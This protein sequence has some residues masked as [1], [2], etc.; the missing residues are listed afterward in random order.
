MHKKKILYYMAE[1]PFSSEAGNLTRCRQLLQYFEARR[2][3]MDVDFISSINWDEDGKT[4][5]ELHY[6]SLGLMIVPFKMEK[7]NII[8]YFLTDKLP[9]EINKILNTSDID[10]VSPYFKKTLKR[11]ISE[12]RYDIVIISYAE[13]GNVIDSDIDAYKILDTHDFTTL[14]L[15][16]KEQGDE[17]IKMGDRFES[18]MNILKKFDEIW[19]YSIEEQFIFEQFAKKKVSLLPISFNTNTTDIAKKDRAYDILYVASANFHNVRSMEWFQEYVQPL[20]SKYK[21]GVVGKIGSM[22]KDAENI[23][24]LGLVE[25]LDQVYRDTKICICPMLS[26]TGVKIKVLEA[27]SF[28]LPVVTN[29]R[30]VDGLINKGQNG[31]LVA[32]DHIEFADYIVRLLE[33]DLF[34]QELSDQAM[35]YFKNNHNREHE[36]EVLDRIMLGK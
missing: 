5:F 32:Q 11:I 30:G 2:E 16:A 22:I 17:T 13:Y 10:R 33:D 20:V 15:M 25:D 18:E 35:M 26:G 23:I 21:I 6:P 28:G 31:C 4:K 12:Q 7:G 9:K 8:R 3:M 24:K 1:N 14:Q 19:T 27:L 29:R 36:F 34:Y